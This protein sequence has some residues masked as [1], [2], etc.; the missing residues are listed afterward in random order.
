MTGG[1][2]YGEVETNATFT[3]TVA[4]LGGPVVGSTTTALSSNTTKAGWVIGAGA[5]WAI[6][7]PWSAKLEYLYMDLGT[8][9]SSFVATGPFTL[10][11]TSSRITDNI[12]RLGV[13]YRVGG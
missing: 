5:E 13:N 7:G 9:S 8:V 10:I 2:A 12:V 1:L 3:N 4:F 6:Y 11:N